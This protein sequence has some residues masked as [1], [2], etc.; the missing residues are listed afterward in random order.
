MYNGR[1]W[2]VS[3]FMMYELLDLLSTANASSIALLVALQ[4]IVSGDIWQRQPIQ[5]MLALACS[6]LCSFAM[7]LF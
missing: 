7:R 5:Q 3:R 6:V 1:L 4:A 2:F